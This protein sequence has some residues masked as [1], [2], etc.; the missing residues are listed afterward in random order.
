MTTRRI[1]YH[2]A[3]APLAACV[4]AVVV[5]CTANRTLLVAWL[6]AF[7][8]FTAAALGALMLRHMF[9]LGGARLAETWRGEFATSA[10]WITLVPA[11]YLAIALGIGTLFGWSSSADFAGQTW[12]LNWP[13]AIVRAIVYFV[14]WFVIARSL[15]A[16]RIRR[17]AVAA[18]LLVLFATANL[19]A[20]DWIIALTPRW[21]S[22]D[23]GLRWCVNGLLTAAAAIVFIQS[24]TRRET[25]AEQLL[26]RI[27]GANLI[28]ALNLGW[29]YLLFV[30]YITA[31]SGNL[32]SE[33]MWYVPRMQGVWW[34]AIAAIVACHVAIGAVL[35][36]RSAKR[37]ATML[38][39]IATFVI[40]IEWVEALWTIVPGTGVHA[41]GAFVVTTL[42][43]FLFAC[44]TWVWFR[45]GRTRSLKESHAHV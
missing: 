39:A 32:P 21:H 24:R 20:T 17:S 44:L 12:Y 9:V 29:I 41:I 42:V 45:V 11:L 33:A 4:F 14:A 1:D 8:F 36:L 34:C 6:C 15:F 40:V 16:P 31:W 10:S 3:I 18:A 13:F 19:A 37:S 7:T 38:S 5:G 25:N 28:F 35:L 22:S 23:F 26:L 43:T 30:D 27:D 2:A